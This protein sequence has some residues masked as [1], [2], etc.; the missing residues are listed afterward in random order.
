M[1]HLIPGRAS[2]ST[3]T[4]RLYRT[5][6]VYRSTISTYHVPINGVSGEI[7]QSYSTND[8]DFKHK[9]TPTKILYNLGCRRCIK[10]IKNLATK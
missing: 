3:N 2:F 9:T 6:G 10:S 4:A 7:P 8:W 5:I 1:Y